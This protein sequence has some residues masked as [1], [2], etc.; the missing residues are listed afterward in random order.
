M[1]NFDFIKLINS[2]YSFFLRVI[3][4]IYFRKKH[5]LSIFRIGV[6]SINR[7]R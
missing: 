6:G 5:E 1:N 2:A 4:A 7:F 3:F